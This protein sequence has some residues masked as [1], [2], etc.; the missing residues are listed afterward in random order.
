MPRALD[1]LID[2]LEKQG[3]KTEADKYRKQLES[4]FPDWKAD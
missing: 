1:N 3:D 2:A 4:E